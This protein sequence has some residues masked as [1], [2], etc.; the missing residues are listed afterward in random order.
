MRRYRYKGNT[1]ITTLLLLIL[2][3]FLLWFI[4]DIIKQTGRE[5]FPSEPEEIEETYQIIEPAVMSTKMIE[6][7]RESREQAEAKAEVLTETQ[8]IA[9]TMEVAAFAPLDNRSGICADSNP[10]TTK[11]NSRPA[12]GTIA[13]NNS[14]IPLGTKLY[15][16]GYG[17]GVAEDTGAIVRERTDL[18]EV[19]MPTYEEACQWGR[20]KDVTVFI[21]VAP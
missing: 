6:A 3:W 2:I 18:I 12:M 4:P 9:M 21:E 20:K 8:Y 1:G 11:N 17:F 19:F 5:I 13:T 14:I 16:E 7:E 10:E 15:V